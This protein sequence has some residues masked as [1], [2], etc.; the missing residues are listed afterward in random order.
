MNDRVERSN[1]L[2]GE[3]G[4]TITVFIARFLNRL[5]VDLA[6][7]RISG[8]LDELVDARQYTSTR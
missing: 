8:I 2:L 1:K 4:L 3:V 7:E 6:V 5:I